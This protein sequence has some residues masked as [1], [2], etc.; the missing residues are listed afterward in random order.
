MGF[1]HTMMRLALIGIIGLLVS[2]KAAAEQK[3][4]VGE[5]EIHYTAFPSLLVPADT[6]SLHGLTRAENRLLLNL[7][8]RR[9]GEPVPAGVR[10]QVVNILNQAQPLTFFEVSE[11]T[12]IYYLAEVVNQEKDWLRFTLEIEFSKDHPPYVLEFNRQYY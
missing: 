4:Q 1:S 12:A 7:S 5:F 8:V 11:Q 6:A 3:I 9:A 10:G 2:F